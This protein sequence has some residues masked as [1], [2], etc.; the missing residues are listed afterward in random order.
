MPVTDTVFIGQPDRHGRRTF[1]WTYSGAVDALLL[2]VDDD[3]LAEVRDAILAELPLPVPEHAPIAASTCT[4]ACN[5]GHTFTPP[6]EQAITPGVV[7]DTV[8]R[9]LHQ[10]RENLC[11]AQTVLPVVSWRAMLSRAV[12]H[13][14]YV[15]ARECPEQWSRFDRTDEAE[16][17]TLG[18]RETA[19]ALNSDTP[20]DDAEAVW[21][22]RRIREVLW[23][24]NPG[25]IPYVH[26]M[27]HLLW[28]VEYDE[29]RA[30]V[31]HD[32]LTTI[33]ADTCTWC[34]G[35]CRG[36]PHPGDASWRATA[37]DVDVTHRALTVHVHGIESGPPYELTAAEARY[38]A[39]DL[40]TGAAVL[41]AI[42]RP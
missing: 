17:D 1:S 40:T 35:P 3:D 8:Y 32:A 31:E 37:V 41:D 34:G 28:H 25:T 42:P 38:L 15:G 22:L 21:S 5:E 24:A 36:G 7:T 14:D 12:R 27:R 2:K 13:I 39:A 11:R 29:R 9:L 10:A 23:N 26:A 33:E 30:E 4:K 16:G 20:L 18:E 19:E 6:C